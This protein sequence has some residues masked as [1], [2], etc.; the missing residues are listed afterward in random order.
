M[1]P[2]TAVVGPLVVV[3]LVLPWRSDV[4]GAA[5]AL[6]TLVVVVAVAARGHRA[7][8]WLASVSAA[9]WF[10]LFLTRPYE[11]LAIATRD[12][13]LTAVLLAGVGVAVTE[14]AVRGRRHRATAALDEGYLH[15]IARVADL[16]ATAGA[17]ATAAAVRTAL[18]EVLPAHEVRFERG[19]AG[20]LPR[21]GGDGRIALR[22]G[23]EGAWPVGQVGLPPT[24]FEIVA[25]RGGVGYG[26][27]VVTA[28]P[29]AHP[30]RTALVVA[31]VLADQAATALAQEA[32]RPTTTARH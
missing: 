27:F 10:D 22:G 28:D 2:S 4:P 18:G 17:H 30:D 7:A 8:G 15:T 24:P 6:L 21:L 29:H 19:Q 20:G 13:V 5:A 16:A 3:L 32:R 25:E 31:K 12:D 9:V 1:P 26:R 11:S 14:L 23:G